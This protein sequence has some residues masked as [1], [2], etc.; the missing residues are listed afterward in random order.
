MSASA[1]VYTAEDIAE[2][3][4]ANE[5]LAQKQLE[6]IKQDRCSNKMKH[7][8]INEDT[9][10]VNDLRHESRDDDEDGEDKGSN[11]SEEGV[12]LGFGLSGSPGFPGGCTS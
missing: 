1:K 4:A 8:L 10:P 3:R 5:A 6:Q 12:F 11:D 9:I 7:K 2:M